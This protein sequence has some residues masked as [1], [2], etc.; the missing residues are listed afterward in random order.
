MLPPVCAI[1]VVDRFKSIT[2]SIVFDGV[3]HLFVEIYVVYGGID[4]CCI[5]AKPNKVKK[6]CP[7][8]FFLGK[9]LA[10]YA[11]NLVNVSARPGGMFRGQGPEQVC[12]RYG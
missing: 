1:S 6:Y 9:S 4:I 7:G 3:V 5:R 2:I 12:P 11:W 10:G 8:A